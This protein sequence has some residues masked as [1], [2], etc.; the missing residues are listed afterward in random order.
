MVGGMGPAAKM[1][2]ELRETPQSALFCAL[3]HQSH[4][5]YGKLKG[6]L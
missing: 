6:T 5:I 4:V 2:S 1:I 3:D